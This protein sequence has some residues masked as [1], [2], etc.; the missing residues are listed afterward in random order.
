MASAFAAFQ[1][2]LAWTAEE[3]IVALR[4]HGDDPALPVSPIRPSSFQ[5]GMVTVPLGEKE[6]KKEREEKITSVGSS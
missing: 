5:G 4:A 1:G 3:E 2:S 6:S